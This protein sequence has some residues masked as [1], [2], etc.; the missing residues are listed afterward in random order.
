M[1]KWIGILLIISVLSSIAACSKR[2]EKEAQI[3]LR[4]TKSTTLP[5]LLPKESSESGVIKNQI[6]WYGVGIYNRCKMTTERDGSNLI[7]QIIWGN[8]ASSSYQYDFSGT[9]K[10][11][12]LT[13]TNLVE[14]EVTTDEKNKI[15]ENVLN[16]DLSGEVYFHNNMA[17]WDNNGNTVVLATDSEYIVE[18]K[19]IDYT[20]TYRSLGLY[21]GVTMDVN[22]I[23]TQISATLYWSQSATEKYIY[24]FGGTIDGNQVILDNIKT[25]MV[26]YQEDGSKKEKVIKKKKSG[27]IFFFKNFIMVMSDE[28]DYVIPF[29]K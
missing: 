22:Q 26:T 19:K 14:K 4:T 23:N 2:N 27:T 9:L 24:T 15:V 7:V 28:D 6:S 29:F 8:S 18:A 21:D 25:T 11:D 17:L 1:K 20:G 5:S 13:Y 12:V 3:E 16:E 10:D